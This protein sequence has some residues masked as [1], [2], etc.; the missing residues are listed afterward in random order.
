M[1]RPLE[2][3]STTTWSMDWQAVVLPGEQTVIVA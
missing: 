3:V 2:P 1:R